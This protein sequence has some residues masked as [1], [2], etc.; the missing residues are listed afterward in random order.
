MILHCIRCG[1]RLPRKRKRLAVGRTGGDGK[2]RPWIFTSAARTKFCS[3]ECTWRYN[4]PRR[5]LHSRTC[6]TCGKNFTGFKEQQ[7]CSR[8][9]VSLL[10]HPS[11]RRDITGQRFGRLVA[12]KSE[13]RRGKRNGREGAFTWWLCQC[14]CGRE[15]WIILSSIVAGHSKSCGCLKREKGRK[16]PRQP[17]NVPRVCVICNA[18]FVGHPDRNTCSAA[19]R[20]MQ[21]LLV[22][23][24]WRTANR[25]NIR[26][27][28]RRYEREYLERAISNPIGEKQWLVKSRVE[29]NRI[30]RA[31]SEGLHPKASASPTR[32]SPPHSN[33]PR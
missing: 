16:R 9:C 21:R 25:E 14:D 10:P 29:L 6:K 5:F 8:K 2:N 13:A 15:K 3:T 12:I 18:T 32:E 24:R 1:E 33:S 11:R 4:N 31:L 28:K 7:Y 20:R 17:K 23:R 30:R 19:H 22:Q 26:E 27:Y